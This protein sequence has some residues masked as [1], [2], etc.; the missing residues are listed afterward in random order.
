MK[1]RQVKVKKAWEKNPTS[2]DKLFSSILVA[3][4]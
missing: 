1:N 2:R 4:P 3:K